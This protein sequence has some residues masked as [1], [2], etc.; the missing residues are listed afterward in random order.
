V[1]TNCD[2]FHRINCE[3]IETVS[4]LSCKRISTPLKYFSPTFRSKYDDST[5]KQVIDETES[6]PTSER[7]TSDREKIRSGDPK[8]RKPLQNAE[9]KVKP[10]GADLTQSTV[11]EITP[12]T[13]P[14]S[15]VKSA[16]PKPT[17]PTKSVDES[18]PRNQND[19]HDND[20]SADDLFANESHTSEP[21]KKP[22]L[23][24]PPP[25]VEKKPTPQQPSAELRKFYFNVHLHTFI[26]F[27]SQKNSTRTR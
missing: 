3:K 27:S 9:S 2:W 21:S 8:L 6:E 18:T 19:T 4:S 13:S 15:K 24:R 10:T 22:E 11:K 20:D 16:P 25:P 17:S 12:I 1:A 26:D 5:G 7:K 14:K 23:S